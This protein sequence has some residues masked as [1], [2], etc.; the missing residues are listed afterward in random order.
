MRPQRFFAAAIMSAISASLVTSASKAMQSPPSFLTSAAVSSASASV[1]VDRHD[2]G[3]LLREAQAGG[4]AVAH[5][6]ARALAGA[7]DDGCFIL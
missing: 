4:A 7:D 1:A 6:A 3:A 2:L 5:A